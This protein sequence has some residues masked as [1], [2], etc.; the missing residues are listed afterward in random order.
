MTMRYW[1]MIALVALCATTSVTAKEAS[2]WVKCDGLA[3]PMGTG[4]AL[5]RLVAIS[6]TFGLLGKPEDSNT[7]DRI[8]G[9]AGVQACDRVLADPV[10]DKFQGRKGLLLKARAIHHLEADAPEAA[11]TDIRKIPETI[12]DAAKGAAYERSLG[13]SLKLLESLALTKLKRFDEADNLLTGISSLR[14]YS[15]TTQELLLLF[16]NN[17]SQPTP[18]KAEIIQRW[19]SLTASAGGEALLEQYATPAQAADSWAK[20]LESPKSEEKIL[21][22][23]KLI[24]KGNPEADALF[25]PVDY[26]RAAVQAARAGRTEQAE[27]WIAKAR[28][29]NADGSKFAGKSAE[30]IASVIKTLFEEWA[31]TSATH[32]TIAEATLL[33]NQSKLA[34]M[35]AKLNGME[36]YPTSP[37]F[38]ELLEK[39]QPLV[40]VA[41]RKGL[42]VTPVAEIRAKFDKP[43]TALAADD[44]KLDML[45]TLLPPIETETSGNSYS[46]Q[47][48]WGLKESGFKD[49]KNKTNPALRTIEFVGTF[50]P[51]ASVEEMS[52]LR[53]AELALKEGK[54]N[55]RLVDLRKYQRFTQ[56]TIN[57][58]PTGPQYPA[59]FK[60]EIDVE[61]VGGDVPPDP[62]TSV[63][64]AQQ[65][66]DDL[67]ARY[68]K[69]KS[70]K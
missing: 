29:F 2:D 48:G 64:S 62:L 20:R 5:G 65:V 55:F 45:F 50:S 47:W 70:S 57:G 60:T 67:S 44:K 37:A 42:W 7:R 58:S 69:P 10:L 13:M 56:M 12:G 61:F 38:Y 32:V 14:P 36:A 8:S 4:E 35:I 6:G 52:M 41:E 51:Q 54:P 9:T 66:W 1:R 63:F 15:A 31:Q 22:I 28:S 33:L 59:G 17:I 34:E 25:N 23:I 11:L 21:T 53:A 68:I 24:N 16:M 19:M 40:P 30:H 39:A 26:A 27:A 46:G 18:A 49:R 3:A 43:R